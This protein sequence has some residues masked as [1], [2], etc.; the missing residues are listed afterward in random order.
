MFGKRFDMAELSVLKTDQEEE[1]ERIRQS[2]FCCSPCG[3]CFEY[4]EYDTGSYY[5]EFKG[6]ERF[7]TICPECGESL[8]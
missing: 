8:E 6:I 5:D 7:Y 1:N 4:G 2:Q 3:R